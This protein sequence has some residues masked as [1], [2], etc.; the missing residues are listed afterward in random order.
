MQPNLAHLWQ[1]STFAIEFTMT[2]LQ[3]AYDYEVMTNILAEI[4][5]VQADSVTVT[6]RNMPNGIVTS[7]L[8]AHEEFKIDEI[9]NKVNDGRFQSDLSEYLSSSASFSSSSV[10]VGN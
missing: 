2:G 8:Y 4:G 5:D 1:T 3:G 6:A 9:V 7:V 10:Q